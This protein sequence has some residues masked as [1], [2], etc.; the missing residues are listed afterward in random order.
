MEVYLGIAWTLACTIVG[1]W[2]GWLDCTR[3][4]KEQAVKHGA[5]EYILDPATGET[6]WQWKKKEEGVK[7]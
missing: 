3:H 5:A 4:F 6:T 7:P 1:C 2:A